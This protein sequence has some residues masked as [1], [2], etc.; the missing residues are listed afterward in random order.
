[1]MAIIDE[2]PKTIVESGSNYSGIG[3]VYVPL[4]VIYCHDL[5]V[6]TISDE[7]RG[8][9]SGIHDN[10]IQK[11]SR[12]VGGAIEHIS[13][14]ITCFLSLNADPDDGSDVRV[15]DPELHN[16]RANVVHDNYGIVVLRNN[17]KDEVVSIIP[18]SEVIAS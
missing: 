3:Q 16:K 10:S 9:I 7:L 15:L 17:G 2:P 8:I 4:R 12:G 13:D 14:S 11:S 5:A 1:M 6:R 18:G